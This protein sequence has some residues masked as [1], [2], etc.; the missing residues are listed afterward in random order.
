MSR[1]PDYDT[2]AAANM[3]TDSSIYW[4][5]PR[6]N[7]S[8]RANME[9]SIVEMQWKWWLLWTRPICKPWRERTPKLNMR[10]IEQFTQSIWGDGS[11]TLEARAAI[12]AGDPRPGTCG[13]C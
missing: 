3:D 13:W 8:D 4:L 7:P 2:P 5:I 9:F 6:T 1:P 12:G 11:A 10:E